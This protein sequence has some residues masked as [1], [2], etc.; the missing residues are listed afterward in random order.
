MLKNGE[1]LKSGVVYAIKKKGESYVHKFKVPKDCLPLAIKIPK[2]YSVEEIGMLTKYK[3]KELKPENKDG[4][5][6][7]KG[8]GRPSRTK[9]AGVEEPGRVSDGDGLDAGGRRRN[10]RSKK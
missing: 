9:E 4:R 2:G 1:E 3:N 7:S 10:R 6:G 8:K 5:Y